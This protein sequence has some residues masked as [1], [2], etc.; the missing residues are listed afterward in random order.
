M[1]FDVSILKAQLVDPVVL[2]DLASILIF[3]AV[4]IAIAVTDSAE[5][6]PARLRRFVLRPLALAMVMCMFDVVAAVGT[7]NPSTMPFAVELAINFVTA[8]IVWAIGSKIIRF[9]RK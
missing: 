4:S 8:S 3:A 9:L 6:E 2:K 1:A 5:N 7:S